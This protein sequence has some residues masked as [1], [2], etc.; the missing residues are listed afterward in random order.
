MAIN[1][2]QCRDNGT[3]VS[4]RLTQLSYLN[5]AV[6]IVVVGVGELSSR[7]TLQVQ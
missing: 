2:C 6:E 3:A 1:V 5:N 4:S 7:D